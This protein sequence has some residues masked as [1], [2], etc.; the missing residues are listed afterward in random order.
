M[1]K[2]ITIYSRD[3]CVQCNA[4]YRALD[5]ADIDYTVE[6]ADQYR[7]MLERE[8]CRSLP[9]VVVHDSVD[10]EESWSGFRPDLISKIKA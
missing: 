9:F 8:G 4:T 1:T 5:K 6:D 10:G 2:T 3:N 7:D